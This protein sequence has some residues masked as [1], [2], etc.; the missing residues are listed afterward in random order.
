MKV[1]THQLK[2]MVRQ[3]G[4]AMLEL[5]DKI[6]DTGDPF[7]EDERQ[8]VRLAIFPAIKECQAIIS[9]AFVTGSTDWV[10]KEVENLIDLIH[11]HDRLN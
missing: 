2:C 3:Q 5:A 11:I 1:D 6:G 8:M 10:D 9:S 4:E 7:T